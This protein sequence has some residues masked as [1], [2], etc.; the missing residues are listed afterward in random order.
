MGTRRA[1]EGAASLAHQPTRR[2]S[3]E[4]GGRDSGWRLPV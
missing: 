4:T 3:E 1:L 2:L